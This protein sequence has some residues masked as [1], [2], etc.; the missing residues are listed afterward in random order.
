MHITVGFIPRGLD[1]VTI[2]A[3][4]FF[5]RSVHVYNASSE[6]MAILQ[7]VPAVMVTDRAA[8]A[9]APVFGGD[10]RWSKGYSLG[11]SESRE[12]RVLDA[13]ANAKDGN[14]NEPPTSV[15]KFKTLSGAQGMRLV[16]YTVTV[17]ET[18]GGQHV[19]PGDFF[20]CSAG[21]D[22]YLL[23]KMID[24]PLPRFREKEVQEDMSE[25]KAVMAIVRG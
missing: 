9:S 23:Q 14:G 8:G 19:F 15:A 5:A 21:Y 18:K 10:V 24:H 4:Q 3:C 13:W 22:Y 12:R 1:L 6:P 16:P 11:D 20:S 17:D 7:V 25:E 2:P